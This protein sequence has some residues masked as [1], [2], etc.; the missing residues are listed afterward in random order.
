MAFAPTE[1]TF[2]MR[3]AAPDQ[4]KN[5]YLPGGFSRFRHS[6]RTHKPLRARDFSL[7]R[8]AALSLL[9]LVGIWEKCALDRYCSRGVK[10]IFS[11]GNPVV[12][13]KNFAAWSKSESRP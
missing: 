10:E 13:G 5:N 6:H 4:R 8:P 9:T 1:S 3:Y 2:S 7:A 12:R 11:G